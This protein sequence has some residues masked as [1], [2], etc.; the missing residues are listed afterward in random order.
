MVSNNSQVF[1]VE[2]ETIEK[3]E[4]QY[5]DTWFLENILYI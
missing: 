2:E 4:A 3:E 1:D 5:S